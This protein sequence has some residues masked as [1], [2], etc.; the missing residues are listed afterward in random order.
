MLEIPQDMCQKR[1]HS[2]VI[3]LTICPALKTFIYGEQLRLRIKQEVE[4]ILLLKLQDFGHI[5]YQE[6][7]PCPRFYEIRCLAKKRRKTPNGFK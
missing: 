2:I 1:V 6:T 7:L 5:S 3:C 4:N